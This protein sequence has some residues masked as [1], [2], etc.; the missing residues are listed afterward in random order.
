MQAEFRRCLV[1]LDVATA[2]KLWAE[3]RPGFVQ[4][5]N[6][7]ETLVMLHHART[8]ARSVPNKLRY[9]SHR[10]LS[11]H[12]MPSGLPD[13]ERPSAERM[14]PKVVEGVGISVNT[15]NEFLQPIVGQVRSAMEYAVADAYA[16]GRTEPEFV[17]VR[18]FE[19]RA[20]EYKKLLGTMT[21]NARH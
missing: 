13:G 18:M 3:T 15:R 5:K 12:G 1:D 14:Y 2:R 21:A 17:R 4:P 6:D 19:A 11:D 8:Q 20:R 9:Y 7:H 16:D 10:W